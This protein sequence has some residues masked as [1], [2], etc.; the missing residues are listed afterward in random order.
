MKGKLF[1][2]I[3]AALIITASVRA[4]NIVVSIF[5]TNTI[6]SF[7]EQGTG[8]PFTNL[9]VIGPNGLAFDT[10]GNLY[11]SVSNNTIEKFGADGS[12][13]GVFA[14]T[15]IN[16]AL[17][18]AFDS[19]GNL[20]AANFGG[21][22]IRKFNPNGIDLGVFA[23]VIRPTGIAFDAA[24]NLYV[25]N[26]SNNVVRFA[27]DGTPLGF[28]AITGLNNPQGIDFDSVGNLY[29]ANTAANT[30]RVFAPDGT[31]MGPLPTTKLSGPIGLAIDRFD[32]IF[33]VNSLNTT[34]EQ[35]TPDGTE[36]VFALTGFSPTYVAVQAAPTL[37]NISTRADVLTG[38]SILDGGFT[39]SGLGT[40]SVLIKGLGPSLSSFGIMDV[41][42][43]P[44]IELHNSTGAIIASNDNWKSTQQSQI[45]ATGLAPTNDAEAALI[46]NLTAG[47]YTVIESG[48]NGGTGVGLVEVYDLNA[49]HGP[50]L[51]NIST[52]GFVG[53]GNDVMIAGFID[54]SSTGTSGQMLLR[55]LGPSLG[56]FGVDNPLA[57]PVLDLFNSNGT[58]IASNDD[59]QS[60]QKDQII[61]T[62]LAPTNPLEA[63]ILI[64]L[65][66]GAY[67]AIESGNS[68][69]TGVGLVEVYNLH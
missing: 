42:A 31:D 29:V 35:I 62:G 19:S 39:I 38:D 41:L 2:T 23:N 52:R 3:A 16:L 18:L 64:T 40:K 17:G 46:A 28:F 33:V 8:S 36:S 32:N 6:T 68:G 43:N 24:G 14:S 51:A 30:I 21:N 58:L 67:T 11:V 56:S 53:V 7:D 63:A 10:S 12:D 44:M 4:D 1:L 34:V 55:G 26:F 22:T 25:A 37:A 50:E 57:N 59:W 20:Y 69:G 9:P 45:E 5:G 13:L 15:G 48:V 65:A 27:P 66:P 60:T 47:A 54:V 49:T 61:A